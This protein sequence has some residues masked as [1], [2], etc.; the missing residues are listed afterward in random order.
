MENQFIEHHLERDIV[1]TQILRKNSYSTTLD[2]AIS[3]GLTPCEKC[4]Y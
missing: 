3:T 2:S 1:M 4:V